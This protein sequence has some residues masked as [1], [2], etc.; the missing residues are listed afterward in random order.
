M[1]LLRVNVGRKTFKE[2]SFSYENLNIKSVTESCRQM[3][4]TISTHY[5]KKTTS[6]V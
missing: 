4:G 1:Q 5:K 6:M 3:L 2:N